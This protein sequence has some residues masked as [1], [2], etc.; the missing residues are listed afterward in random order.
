M[1]LLAVNVGDFFF[2]FEFILLR[3]KV[4]VTDQ[5]Y[6]LDDP[7]AEWRNEYKLIVVARVRNRNI[8][9]EV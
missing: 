7:K 1:A 6:R 9:Y 2:L 8:V 4:K 3:Y 5:I